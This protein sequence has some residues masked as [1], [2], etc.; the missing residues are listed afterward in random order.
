M[1]ETYGASDD[2]C[3]LNDSCDDSQ[4]HECVD[5]EHRCVV[6]AAKRAPRCLKQFEAIEK[7]GTEISYRCVDMCEV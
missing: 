1:D 3:G 4:D 2:Y 6:M 7:S 5:D